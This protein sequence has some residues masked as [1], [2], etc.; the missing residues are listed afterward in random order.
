MPHQTT[1]LPIMLTDIQDRP[2]IRE[3]LQCCIYP[4]DTDDHPEGIVNISTGRIVSDSVSVEHAVEIGKAQSIS[5]E[6][7]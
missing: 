6:S 1:K 2:K 4:M 3:K 7:T 5:F